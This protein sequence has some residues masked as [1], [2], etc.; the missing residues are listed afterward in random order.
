MITTKFSWPEVGTL[1]TDRLC[2]INNFSD[3]FKR[4]LQEGRRS[5][6]NQMFKRHTFMTWTNIMYS[7]MRL[8]FICLEICCANEV[9]T[10]GQTDGHGLNQ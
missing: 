2:I 7:F 10:N 6:V 3:V 8:P 4:S 5:E 9:V 1:P